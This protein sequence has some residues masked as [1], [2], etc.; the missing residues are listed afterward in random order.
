MISKKYP[1]ETG[2]NNSRYEISDLTPTEF[3]KK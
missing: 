1:R 3:N 2:G